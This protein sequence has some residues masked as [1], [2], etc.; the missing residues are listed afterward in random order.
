MQLGCRSPCSSGAAFSPFRSPCRLGRKGAMAEERAHGGGRREQVQFTPPK[1][2]RSATEL[3]RPMPA[4][5]A[6]SCSSTGPPMAFPR[7]P[8][9]GSLASSDCHHSALSPL[10]TCVHSHSSP[11]APPAACGVHSMRAQRCLRCRSEVVCVQY[12]ERHLFPLVGEPWR[13]RSEMLAMRFGACV[14]AVERAPS[15]SLPLWS[16]DH[17]SAARRRSPC[18]ARLMRVHSGKGAN[19]DMQFWRLLHAVQGSFACNPTSV[20]AR[21]SAASVHAQQ[22]S[23]T[24]FR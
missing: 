15:P 14:R 21:L 22:R 24:T 19:H 16:V 17:D 12:G 6:S 13:C 3:P 8:A 7:R 2:A 10:S 9:A 4:I 20:R 18:G 23:T 5:L 11:A 1:E